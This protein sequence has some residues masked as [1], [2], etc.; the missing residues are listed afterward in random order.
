MRQPAVANLDALGVRAESH[1]LADILVAQRHR[2]FH[3][4]VGKAHALTATEIKIAVREM[5]IAVADPGGQNLQQHFT[6]GWLRR[7]LLIELQRLPAN[8]DLE[9]SHRRFSPDPWNCPH[10]EPYSAPPVTSRA[11]R[12]NLPCGA[13]EIRH[14]RNICFRRVTYSPAS[15]IPMAQ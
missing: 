13:L 9:H 2:Q 1:H 6:A 3:A 5:Q 14:C 8:A 10:N 11:G 12:R 4:A 7:G 15:A